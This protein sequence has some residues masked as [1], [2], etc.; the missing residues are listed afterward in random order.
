[1]LSESIKKRLKINWG[2]KANALDC[3]AEVKLIDPLSSWCCYIFAM[4]DNED[5]I[6]CLGYSNLA[7]VQILHQ[8]S[9]DAILSMYNQEGEYPQI[10]TEF[11]RMKVS[12]LIKRLQNDS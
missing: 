6:Q 3:Y 9:L 10:D 8:I 12:Q 1:M 7:G 11:R 4:N 5:L 2:E